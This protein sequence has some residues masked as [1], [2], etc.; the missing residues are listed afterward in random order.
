MGQK[1]NIT[2]S[3]KFSILKKK[4]AVLT[5]RFPGNASPSAEE[6]PHQKT[7]R[8]NGKSVPRCHGIAAWVLGIAGLHAR[9]VREDRRTIEE[10]HGC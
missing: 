2:T 9:R 7:R 10:L 8:A 6:I 4:P 5:F 3:N 1:V